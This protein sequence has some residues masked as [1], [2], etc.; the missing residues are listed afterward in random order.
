MTQEPPG[1]Y[2]PPDEQGDPF[3]RDRSR[4]LKRL[5]ALAGVAAAIAAVVALAVTLLGHR[6]EL[7]ASPGPLVADL[8][9]TDWSAPRDEATGYRRL[10]TPFRHG[11]VTDAAAIGPDGTLAAGTRLGDEPARVVIWKDRRYRWIPIGHG[12]RVTAMA[13]D[14]DGWVYVGAADGA[15]GVVDP[16]GSAVQWRP[17]PQAGN[18]VTGFAFERDGRRA[19]VVVAGGTVFT[20]ERPLAGELDEMVMPERAR[21]RIASFD[22]DGDVLVAGDAAAAFSW[23]GGEWLA[24]PLPTTADVVALG[25]DSYGR[26]LAGQDNGHVFVEDGASWSRVGQVAVTPAAIGGMP[27]LGVVVAGG[28]SRAWAS[29]D[30]DDF[31]ELGLPERMTGVRLFAGQVAGHDLLMVSRERLFVRAG[32]A[33][34][35]SAEAGAP[36]GLVGR[37]GC[38]AAGPPGGAAPLTPWLRCGEGRA[39]LEG[40]ALAAMTAVPLEGVDIAPHELERALESQ[41]DTWLGGALIRCAPRHEAPAVERLSPGT[42]GFRTWLATPAEEGHLLSVAATDD[43]LWTASSE[44]VIRFGR[45]AGDAPPTLAEVHRDEPHD[46]Y[47]G[48]ELFPFGG[49]V[50]AT[51]RTTRG[52][53]RLSRLDA[54]RP[55][56]ARVLV[57]TVGRGAS[58]EGWRPALRRVGARLLG[59]DAGGLFEVDADGAL[60]DF[61]LPDG[62]TV[63]RDDLRS[64]HGV[65]PGP[66]GQ[67][68]IR[69]GD[70]PVLRCEARACL[71][72]ALPEDVFVRSVLYTSDGRL[73]VVEGSGV[74]GI[75]EPR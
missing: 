21:I 45:V 41:T 67:L 15:V 61:A 38:R 23:T 60:H 52:G 2:V 31:S 30:R 47:V 25:H 13:V 3:R 29:Y 46:G 56:E 40:G 53:A 34:W 35:D 66:S 42:R 49:G 6:A 14:A 37:E 74:V 17:A 32:E 50:A 71:Q 64:D 43:E 10:V 75:V 7:P 22:E 9:A 72:I 62:V 8:E 57:D 59:V 44:M 24:R 33:V 70:G 36:P 73:A 28:E 16:T 20:G 11:S 65:A 27:E 68:V 63:G 4:S 5:A 1:I 55:G 18:S 48:L 69:T 12:A 54:G 26:L 58:R 19:L 51:L 39:R